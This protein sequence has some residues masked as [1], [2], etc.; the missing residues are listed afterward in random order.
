MSELKQKLIEAGALRQFRHNDASEGLVTAYDYEV[1]N[2][3]LAS[4]APLPRVQGGSIDTQEFADVAYAFLDTAEM[5]SEV[6]DDRYMKLV[7]YIDA[8]AVCRA[9]PVLG[10][11]VMD[12]GKVEELTRSEWI[13][14]DWCKYVQSRSIVE[15][16]A[17]PSNSQ[18]EGA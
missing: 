3:I 10:Y 15:V 7:A 16:V 14:K 2:R 8:W 6:N 9:G 17:A 1:T 13:A 18:K 12:N 11:A 5:M 4:A